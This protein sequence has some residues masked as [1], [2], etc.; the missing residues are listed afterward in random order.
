MKPVEVNPLV[1]T[2]NI[3][4]VVTQDRKADV[5]PLTVPEITMQKAS[6]SIRFHNEA[7]KAT[8]RE[9]TEPRLRTARLGP[10]SE[11]RFRATP[12]ETPDSVQNDRLEKSNV[13]AGAI[14]FISAQEA[15]QP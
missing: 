15:N 3:A 8:A 14:R 5:R 12:G 11:L 9:A 2:K 13:T 10:K 7:E 4:A 1:R 6:A